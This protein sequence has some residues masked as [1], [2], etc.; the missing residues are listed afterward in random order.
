[1]TG[2]AQIVTPDRSDIRINKLHGVF[3]RLRER[4]G[5]R[6]YTLLW[7][8]YDGDAPD[9]SFERTGTTFPLTP[10]CLGLCWSDEKKIFLN[11]RLIS[12]P[13]EM[14]FVL[15]H[16]LTHARHPKQGERLGVDGA[17]LFCDIISTIHLLVLKHILPDV[18]SDEP[19]FQKKY[20]ETV[21]TFLQ[22]GYEGYG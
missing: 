2:K 1:M 19:D 20:A 7:Y 6:D 10:G 5:L 12:N 11:L 3:T 22:R 8:V 13:V 9:V 21:G 4:F 14:Y 17:E 16:E 15:L 18:F